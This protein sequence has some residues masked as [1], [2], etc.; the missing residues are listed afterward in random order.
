MNDKGSRNQG[1]RPI[2]IYI[3]DFSDD[4]EI[5]EGVHGGAE[6]VEVEHFFTVQIIHNI[7]NGLFAWMKL[8]N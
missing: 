4:H 3:V 8:A 1:R 6:V 7:S 5:G 2:E